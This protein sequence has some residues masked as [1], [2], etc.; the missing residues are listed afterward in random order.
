MYGENIQFWDRIAKR[1]DWIT[2]KLT[3]DYS[4]L[5]QRIVGEIDGAENV[6]E[7]ATGSGLIA[8]ELA[9]KVK[10]IEAVDIS[11]EMIE[12][13]KNKASENRIENIHFSVQSAYNLDFEED[14]FDVAICSNALHC[15]ETPKQALS[16]I[17]RVLKPKGILIAPTFCHGVSWRSRLISRLMSLTGFKSYHRFTIEEF[18]GVIVSSGF[19]IVRKDISRDFIPLAYVV[20]KPT[21]Y[22]RLVEQD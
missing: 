15:M 12:L 8:I 20:A 17:R 19:A 9:R 13:A 7:V 16:E 5:I 3:K 2:L 10:L 21:P 14:T 6:L 11:S 4:A 22:V 18:F 1:Y